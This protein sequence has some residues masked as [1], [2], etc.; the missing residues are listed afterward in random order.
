MDR[1]N[2]E[3]CSFSCPADFV[4]MYEIRRN[5]ERIGPFDTLDGASM[6]LRDWYPKASIHMRS[7]PTVGGCIALVWATEEDSY[8]ADLSSAVA[9]VWIVEG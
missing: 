2:C 1:F 4:P 8:Q 5:L 9:S 7:M 6:A 3:R